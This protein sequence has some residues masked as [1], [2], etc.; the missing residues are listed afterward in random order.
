MAR[1]HYRVA[2]LGGMVR[3]TAVSR[4]YTHVVVATGYKAEVRE[5]ERQAD[6]AERR[7]RVQ[8]YRLV[9]A[10]GVNPRDT[11][12]WQRQMTARCLA[13]GRYAA[14]E[15]GEEEAIAALEAQGPVTADGTEVVAL[16]WC[17]RLDLAAKV[18]AGPTARKYRTV[19]IVPTGDVVGGGQR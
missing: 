19:V 17:G 1:K 11:T 15:A 18:A 14:W 5:E 3:R 4:V 2:A 6:L 7:A 16:G 8:H 13:E 10:T 12:D 9:R